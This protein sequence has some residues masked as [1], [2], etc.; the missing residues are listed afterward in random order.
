MIQGD[1]ERGDNRGRPLPAV[2]QLLIALHFYC[3]GSHQVSVHV[4]IFVAT[5]T[6]LITSNSMETLATDIITRT[7][8]IT[9]TTHLATWIDLIPSN[10]MITLATN[11]ATRTDVYTGNPF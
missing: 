9:L 1:L 11:I 5:G 10:S 2:Y 3:S 7:G 8:L 6:Y 4:L